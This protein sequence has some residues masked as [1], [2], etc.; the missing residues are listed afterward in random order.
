[1]PKKGLKCFILL[2]MNTEYMKV[3]LT[4]GLSHDKNKLSEYSFYILV[5]YCKYPTIIVDK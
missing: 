4:N 2:V 5:L 3:K 1:M